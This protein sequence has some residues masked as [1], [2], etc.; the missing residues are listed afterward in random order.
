MGEP[1]ILLV[2][3]DAPLLRMVNLALVM[4]GFAVTTAEDGRG[5]LEQ[6]HRGTFD[7]I[8]L[9]LQMPVMDGRTFYREMRARGFQTPVLIL[10]AHGAEAAK[11]DLSA[12]GAL[13]KPFD[14]DVLV[15][16]ALDLIQA[17]P[18]SEEMT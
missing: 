10:S 7:L 1:R 8:I 13:V 6:L 16:T 2:D 4:E 11:R 12:S 15:R 17:R 18:I 3:D 9:D 5:A 14:P